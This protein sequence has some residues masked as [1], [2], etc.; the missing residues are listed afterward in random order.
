[1]TP[2][3]TGL[4]TRPNKY[5][6]HIQPLLNGSK[7]DGFVSVTDVLAIIATWGSND[8][9]T[10]IDGNGVVAIGDLL[11]AIGNWGVCE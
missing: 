8:P 9:I 6:I 7:S 5:P 2:N 10:D 11:T 1:M 4:T 3:K